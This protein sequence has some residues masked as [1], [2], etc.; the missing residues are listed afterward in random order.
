MARGR[1]IERAMERGGV[2]GFSGNIV[3]NSPMLLLCVIVGLNLNNNNKNTN[4]KSGNRGRGV[5]KSWEEW[6]G[7]GQW[8]N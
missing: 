3:K 7:E 2:A 1:I 6:V 8:H 4:H 5:E